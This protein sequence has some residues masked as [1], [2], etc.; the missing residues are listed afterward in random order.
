M[1]SFSFAGVPNL[2]RPEMVKE[3]ACIIDV[4]ISRLI[5]KSTGKS[6]LVGDVDFEGQFLLRYFLILTLRIQIVRSMLL[7]FSYPLQLICSIIL[8][9]VSCWFIAY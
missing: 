7:L 6:Q 4:G 3:G 1:L 8:C 5:D 2:I 9:N